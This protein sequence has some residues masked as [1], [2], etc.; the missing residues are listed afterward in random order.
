M[1]GRGLSGLVRR[2]SMM[3]VQDRGK[4]GPKGI[5]TAW[6]RAGEGME[7]K[8]NGVSSAIR[9]VRGEGGT[10]CPSRTGQGTTFYQKWNKVCKLF[11]SATPS[12][13]CLVLVLS[14]PILALFCL[15]LNVCEPGAVGLE[16]YLR[17]SF[18][19]SV[20]REAGRWVSG[21]EGR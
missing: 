20:R 21:I 13:V 16:R 3:K 8:D 7:E 5:A 18:R 15:P 1:A 19:D 11:F 9:N 14:C 17:A 4:E 12:P 2:K 6:E 10:R